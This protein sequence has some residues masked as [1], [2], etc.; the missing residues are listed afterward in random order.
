MILHIKSPNKYLL[1]LLFKNPATDQG[2]YFK[3]LKKGII[4]GNAVSAH[5]YEV[6][7]QD[8]RNSYMPEESNRIDFQS[9]CCPLVVLHICT[10]LFAH[11]LKDKT[12]FRDEPIAWLGTTQGAAD[13]EPCTVFIPTFISTLPGTA[14]ACS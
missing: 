5:E 8:S 6:V 9:Y 1:D 4:A 2:L 11:L 12:A 3:A 13:T 14:M 10:E 7:F